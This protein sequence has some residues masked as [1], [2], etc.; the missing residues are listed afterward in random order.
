MLGTFSVISAFSHTFIS[1]HKL[2]EPYVLSLLSLELNEPFSATLLSHFAAAAVESSSCLAPVIPASLAIA[3]FV[4]VLHHYSQRLS[5]YH[6]H[7]M[8]WWIHLTSLSSHHWLSDEF[9][10]AVAGS[11]TCSRA[12][13]Y[14]CLVRSIFGFSPFQIPGCFLRLDSYSKLLHV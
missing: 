5:P 11:S 10:A 9:A 1:S 7:Q 13:F 3:S 4:F 8:I 12:S 6:L 2:D 14:Q